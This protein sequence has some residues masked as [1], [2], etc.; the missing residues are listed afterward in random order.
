MIKTLWNK[1]YICYVDIDI[2]TYVDYASK[3]W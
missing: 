2:D 3:V 1:P